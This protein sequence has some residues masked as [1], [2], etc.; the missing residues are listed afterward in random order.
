MPSRWYSSELFI[1]ITDNKILQTTNHDTTVRVKLHTDVS[2]L[3]VIDQSLLHLCDGEGHRRESALTFT[4][5]ERGYA[6]HHSTTVD[7]HTV[8]K[9][10]S[11]CWE[12]I[13]ELSLIPDYNCCSKA[14][15]LIHPADYPTPP[16]PN[17][18]PFSEGAIISTDFFDNA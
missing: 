16:T 14:K 18:L 8:A 17:Q 4:Q 3:N 1:K 13:K 9:W 5:V 11:V 12:T 6:R 15:G 2:F 7:S 10:H